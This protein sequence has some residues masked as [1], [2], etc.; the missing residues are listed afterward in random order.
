MERLESL[1]NFPEVGVRLGVC[2]HTPFLYMFVNL[3]NGRTS[4]Q[5]GVWSSFITLSLPEKAKFLFSHRP[6]LKRKP[7]EIMIL[8]SVEFV[9]QILG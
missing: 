8:P 2:Y 3:N 1:R 9:V 5:E 7:L 4:S 6:W